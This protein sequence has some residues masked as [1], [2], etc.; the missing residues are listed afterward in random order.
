M[1]ETGDMLRKHCSFFYGLD[2]TYDKTMKTPIHL[3]NSASSYS[4]CAFMAKDE[5]ENQNVNANVVNQDPVLSSD[6]F[7]RLR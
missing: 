7:L 2:G 5:M 3:Y 4:F 6:N 1:K